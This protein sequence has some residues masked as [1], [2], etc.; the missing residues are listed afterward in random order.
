MKLKTS[1]FAMAATSALVGS[2]YSQTVIDVTGSTAG[3]S[4]VH[5]QIL[6][7]LSS[8]TLAW[9]GGSN[10]AGAT[11]VIYK[12]TYLGNPVIVRTFWSGSAAGVRDIANAPQLNNSYFA[13]ST[14]TSA[15]TTSAGVNVPS[16]TLA[17]ASAETVSEIGFSDVFQTSTA[18]TSNT[19]VQEDSVGVIPFKF[20]K[21]EGASAS[22]TNVTPGLHRTL[23]TGLGEAPL[24]LFTGNSGDA[25]TTV[26]AT[27]RDEFS[28][29]RITCLAETGTGVFAT[30]SQYTG[31][32][33]SNVA[34]LTYV[35]NGGFASG[36]GVSTLLGGTYAGGTILGYLGASDWTTA[37]SGGAV[38]VAYN[39]ITLGTNSDLI[40][41]GQYSFWGYLH[42]FSMTLTGTTATFYGDLKTNLL[43]APGTG[44]ILINSMNVERAA[45]GAP[46]TPL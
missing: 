6:A 43:G 39:G 38:E 13:T 25:G 8:E 4:A 23:Y 18:F 7:L 9:N 19:L 29:T 37:V 41:N 42:Q 44:L 5:S 16:P 20:F 33:A 46:I 45:D 30:L 2:A 35:G 24:S 21:N 32:V 11:R 12:G 22:L 17:A 40:R 28:G 27:G 34:T 31:T 3:R 26:F 14:D 15:G 10:A 36:S 1:L